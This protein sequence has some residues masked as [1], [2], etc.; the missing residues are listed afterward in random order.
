M[1]TPKGTRCTPVPLANGDK[2][3]VYSDPQQI[4]L[5]LRHQIATEADVL[6][7]SFKVAVA[8]NPVEAI[9]IACELFTI[10][11]AR[12][13]NLISSTNAQAVSE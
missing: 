4:V 7:P 9:A 6:G 2:V 11:S 5:Q 12:L 10:A 13:P 1:S 3:H 8:L